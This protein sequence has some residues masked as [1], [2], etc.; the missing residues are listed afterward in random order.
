MFSISAGCC[1]GLVDTSRRDAVKGGK[2]AVIA[3]SI[4]C[5]IFGVLTTLGFCG[6]MPQAVGITFCVLGAVNASLMLIMK[7]CIY[8]SMEKDDSGF[9]ASSRPSDECCSCSI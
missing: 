2:K 4:L 5:I 3:D 6:V 1:M 9:G 8:D 7:K